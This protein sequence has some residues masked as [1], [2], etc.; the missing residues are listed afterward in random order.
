MDVSIVIPVFNQLHFTKICLESLRETVASTVQIVV[1]DNGSTDGTAEYL[2]AYPKI[3]VITNKDNQGCAVAWNQGV[4]ASHASWIAI[5]NNDVILPNNWLDGLLDFASEKDADIVSPAFREGEYN[6]DIAEY[7]EDYVRCMHS[8]A[9]MGIAQGI[10]FMVKRRVF[11]RIGMFDET[12]K[13][14]Q[15]EDA[16]FF[17]RAKIAGLILGTTGRSFIH[18]FASITQNSIRKEANVKPYEAENRAYF[19]RKWRLTWWKRFPVRRYVKLRDFWWR[20]SEKTI[21]GHTLIEKWIDGRLR[22]F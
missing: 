5:L 7:S 20:V 4:R 18:H 19:R 2:A 10:C 1:I 22:Y 21:Y 13:I 6:Y 9:R 3:R 14:G 8:V 12:F 16:D 17:R 15:F 11:E